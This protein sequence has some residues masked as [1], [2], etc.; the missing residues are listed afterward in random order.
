M[1]KTYEKFNY[2]TLRILCEMF[3]I[4]KKLFIDLQMGL[5]DGESITKV[6]IV[7]QTFIQ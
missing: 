4:I 6:R 3:K 1:I 7:K 2:S 5:R